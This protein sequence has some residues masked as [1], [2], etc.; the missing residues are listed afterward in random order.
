MVL[1]RMLCVPIRRGGCIYV[2]GRGKKKERGG[3][4][5]GLGKQSSFFALQLCTSMLCQNVMNMAAKR[6]EKQIPI[7]DKTVM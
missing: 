1:H 3:D 5:V 7:R 6:N 2:G 4:R